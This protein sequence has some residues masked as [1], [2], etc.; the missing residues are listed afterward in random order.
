[1]CR[2]KR[3]GSRVVMEVRMRQVKAS[4]KGGSWEPVR[5]TKQKGIKQNLPKEEGVTHWVKYCW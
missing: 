2:E 4:A 5:E 1:M 3:S